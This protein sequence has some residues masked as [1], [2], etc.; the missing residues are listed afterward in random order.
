[1]RENKYSRIVA[2]P[3]AQTMYSEQR[4]GGA[5][6][7]LWLG[8][9]YSWYMGTNI[10]GKKTELLQFPGGVPMYSKMCNDSAAKGYEGFDLKRIPTAA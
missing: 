5:S 8:A 2:T 9:K 6:R 7:V 10:P 3:E 1:M 4:Q